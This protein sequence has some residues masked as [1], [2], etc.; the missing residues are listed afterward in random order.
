MTVSLPDIV[1]ILGVLISVYLYARVQW[2][3]DYAKNM[4][5]S[6]G[7]FVGSLMIIFSLAY[8]WN[9]ASF[10]SNMLWGVISL[11]GVYRCWKYS[12]GKQKIEQ[13]NRYGSMG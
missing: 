10:L 11:Y 8:N 12:C 3:R 7:N 6:V 4:A 9:V 2:H 13:Q 5:Y 1:G